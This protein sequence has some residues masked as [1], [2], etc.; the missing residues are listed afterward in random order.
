MVCPTCELTLYMP[1]PETCPRCG[2]SIDPVLAMTKA[3]VPA[4]QPLHSADAAEHPAASATNRF[5]IA[6]LVLS[7]VWLGGFGSFLGLIFGG[8]ALSQINNAGERHSGRGLA[9][10]GMTIGSL[11]LAVIALT[12]IAAIYDTASKGRL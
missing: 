11:G 10:A 5:A 1:L 9:I 8:V 3:P 6:S 7:V 12:V 2:N 4:Q